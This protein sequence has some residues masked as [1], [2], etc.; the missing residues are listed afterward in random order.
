MSL[1]IRST[2][3]GRDDKDDCGGGGDEACRLD[4]LD[5]FV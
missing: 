1:A 2:S 4:A 5:S 3:G